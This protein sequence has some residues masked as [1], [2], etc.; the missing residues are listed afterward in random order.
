M[1]KAEERRQNRARDSR[2][3]GGAKF[4]RLDNRLFRVRRFSQLLARKYLV[5]KVV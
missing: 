2:D 5:V 4:H 1:T 3:C